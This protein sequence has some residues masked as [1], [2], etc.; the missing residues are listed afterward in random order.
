MYKLPENT[1]GWGRAKSCIREIAAYAAA[2]KAEIGPDKVYDFTIGNPSIPAPDCV[3]EAIAEII[4][5]DSLAVHGYTTAAGLL[6]LRTK[7]AADINGRFGLNVDPACIYVTCGAAAGLTISLR[8][9][10]TAGD[11][12]IV[13]APFFTEYRVFV[14]GCGGKL[15]VIPPRQDMQIDTEALKCAINEHTRAM[16]INT[17]NNPSGVVFDE[18][19]L[20]ETAA[21][22][23]EAEERLGRP[24]YLIS[25]EPY[26]EIV[27]DLDKVPEPLEYYDD[28]IMV[29][30]FSK[31]LSVPG[32]RIGYIAISDRCE[33][34]YDI[35]AS[36]AG[37][38]RCLGYVNPPSLFQMVIERTLGATSDMAQYKKNR[39]ILCEGLGQLGYEFSKPGGAFYLFVKALEDD[40]KAFCERAKKHELMLVPSDDFGVGGY[41]RVAYCAS[42]ATI[43]NS[44]PAWEALMKEYRG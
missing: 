5:G 27:H 18:E 36:V 7:I 16:I 26:R 4:K 8:S 12:V 44:M 29:Y 41:V 15:V 33:G 32:E 42:E 35:A 22:L 2:R 40:A 39:D 28:S 34:S 38:G 31:C 25:D 19:N 10:M 21:V 17:P 23:R 43:R 11:E 13:A 37:A 1:L 9:I 6:S 30:S 24:V 20:K 3:N 14:E